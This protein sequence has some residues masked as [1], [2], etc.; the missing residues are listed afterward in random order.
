M[1]RPVVFLGT[2]FL[3]HSLVAASSAPPAVVS[4]LYACYDKTNGSL[5]VVAPW[6]G[7]SSG[8][9]CH[10][11]SPWDAAGGYASETCSAGGAFEC[12]TSEYYTQLTIGTGV[13]HLNGL[14]KDVTID[15]TTPVFITTSP[16]K[17]T[18][19]ATTIAG[20]QGPTG[21][22]GPA[23]AQGGIGPQGPTGA[24]GDKGDKG[25][26]G[27][28]FFFKG[29]YSAASAYASNDVVTYGG[30]AFV[31]TAHAVAGTTP[32]NAPW[33]QFAA[34]GDTGATGAQGPQGT[35]GDTGATGAQGPQGNI[36]PTGAQGTKGDTGSTGPQGA[37]GPT[38]SQGSKGDTG[39]TGAQG[40]QGTKG[41]TGATGAQGTQGDSGSTGPQG[42][43]GPTGP[44]GSKG[45]TGAT[46]AQGP[47]GNTGSTGPQG[48]IGPTGSQGSKGDNGATGAQGPNGNTGATGPQGPKGDTGSTGLQGPIGPTGSQGAKGDTGT[49]G[50]QGPNG[51]TGATG[52]Q[53]SKGDTGTTG[54]QGPNGNTGATGPQG[55][56]G[57]TG[58]TGAQGSN[59][60]TGATGPQGAKGDTGATGAQ[61][62]NGS[63]GATGPQGPIGPTGPKG[64]TGATGP[65]GAANVSGTTN[66]VSK[67]TSATTLGN[68]VIVDTGTAVGIGVPI[69]AY[70]FTVSSS[71]GV[72]SAHVENTNASGDGFTGVN[73][74][75]SAAGN[76]SGVVG[77]TNQSGQLAA[78]VWA[79]NNNNGGPA[80]YAYNAAAA[81]NGDGTGAVG[82]TS[83]SAGFGVFG[84]NLHASGTGVVG[85]GQGVTGV[86]LIAGSGG[87]FTGSTT[88]IFAKVN[89]G[90]GN[91]YA[92]LTDNVGAQVAVNAWDNGIHYKIIGTGNVST[93]V[94]DP[95][96]RAS[97]NAALPR[98]VALFAP[99]S[100]E[101]YF[102]DFGEGQ[103][104][105]GSTH[106][107]LDT[108]LAA[109]VAIN[110][111][112][113]LRVFI[114]VEDDEDSPGV[115]VKN[116]TAHGF[117]VVERQKGKSNAH[118]QWQIIANRADE[119]LGDHLARNAD[120]R[121]PEIDRSDKTVASEPRDVQ[122][123]M[124]KPSARA[125]R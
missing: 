96:R 51:N 87:A 63:T 18:I 86:Y 109:N 28:G 3:A 102:M 9:N 122:S 68:S 114:Q 60:N 98:S 74:A 118:F 45:D 24:K 33:A 111:K 26:A 38:G 108:I 34:R 43:I 100:P 23:G 4:T 83:Q 93:V 49:T 25:D 29:E 5:R 120:A 13:D 123:I 95:A 72:T 71:N 125:E 16:N 59:G 58:A 62:S 14:A 61:G 40:P 121:F 103:L 35:K 21:A 1:R 32:G 116:K 20:P 92:V 77:I 48:P 112:H 81:S 124:R 117:D 119:Q 110:S 101:V 84:V 89:S 42:P 113:P 6:S 80:L 82:T 79:Q 64:D 22:T 46:G 12:R 50:A 54:A 10:P 97:A 36:G 104:R 15:A 47:N 90:S 37:I 27:S 75:G 106:I 65:A 8:A 52:P 57:D 66:F 55:A 85:Q 44:Q 107:E 78:G 53:G 94:K 2:L 7:P 115:V 73:A 39:A 30:I 88:G 56:K 67:F 17:I 19:G 70:P 76:G 41:D 99:E 105:N 11:P 69:P 91:T 31:A